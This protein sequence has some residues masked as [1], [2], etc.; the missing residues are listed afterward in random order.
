[1]DN[2]YLKTELKITAG[3]PQILRARYQYGMVLVGM[4]LLKTE[5]SAIPNDGSVDIYPQNSEDEM[6]PEDNVFRVTSALAPV[7][8][9][10]VEHLGALSEEGLTTEG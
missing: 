1:M 5:T 9:P 4:A 8:L 6:S 3:K 2:I 10:L 7:L